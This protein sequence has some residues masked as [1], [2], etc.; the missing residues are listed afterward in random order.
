MDLLLAT[1]LTHR[2]DE[3]CDDHSDD[4]SGSDKF[5]E[6]AQIW[7][8]RSHRRIEDSWERAHLSMT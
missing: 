4:Y 2:R 1:A 6:R 3:L 5:W 7:W 8:A